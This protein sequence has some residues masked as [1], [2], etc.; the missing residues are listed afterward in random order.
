MAG[1][2]MTKVR[3]TKMGANKPYYAPVQ[4]EN[5]GAMPTYG[6]AQEMSEFV[7][8]TENIQY[9]EAEFYSNNRMSESDRAYKRADLSYQ[10][11]GI[12]PETMAAIYGAE[13]SEEGELTFGANQKSPRIGFG[14]Y[15]EM[16]DEGVRYYEGVLYPMV[17][18]HMTGE[19]DNTR[20]ENITYSG[21]TTEMVAYALGDEAQTWKVTKIFATA[22]EAEAWVLGKLGKNA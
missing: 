6:E 1:K 15:R 12:S 3:R 7:A 13:L 16:S 22:A 2:E 5:A 10:N 18:A 4:Q 9:A 11:K 21:D 17:Q 14:F 8:L 20:G 19:T